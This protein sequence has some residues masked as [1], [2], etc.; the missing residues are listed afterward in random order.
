MAMDAD[1]LHFWAGQAKRI[2]REIEAAS[3]QA[4]RRRRW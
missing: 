4:S 2:N 3:R 1:D